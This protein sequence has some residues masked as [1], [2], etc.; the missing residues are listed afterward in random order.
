MNGVL[1]FK[2]VGDPERGARLFRERDCVRCHTEPRTGHGINVPA[3][4][5]GAGSKNRLEWVA[6]YLLAPEPLRYRSEGKRP[7]MRMPAL[8]TTLDDAWDL[9]TLLSTWRDTSLVPEVPEAEIWMSNEALVA[10]G[11]MLFEQY[12]CSGCHSLAGA[13]GEVGPAL[14]GVG[15]APSVIYSGDARGA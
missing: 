1:A 13:G 3:S 11:R 9:A 5:R 15:A 10:E 2:G 6:A 7:D 8:V 4:L 12:Q 14:D